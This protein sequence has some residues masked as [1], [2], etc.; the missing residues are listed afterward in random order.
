MAPVRGVG[1]RPAAVQ[2]ERLLVVHGE[3]SGDGKC[4]VLDTETVGAEPLAQQMDR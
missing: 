3:Y 4:N 2:G 1:H